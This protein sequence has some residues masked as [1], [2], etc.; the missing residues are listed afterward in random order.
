MV[1]KFHGFKNYEMEVLRGVG[2][3]KVSSVFPQI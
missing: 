1:L 3:L 2:S